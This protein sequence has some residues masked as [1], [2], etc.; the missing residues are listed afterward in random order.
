MN[1][2]TTI[3]QLLD[4]MDSFVAEGRKIE[5]SDLPFETKVSQLSTLSEKYG[6]A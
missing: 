6:L 4:A 2:P 3:T 1:A 5:T